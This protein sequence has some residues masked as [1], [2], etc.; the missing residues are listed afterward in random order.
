VEQHF[1]VI[2]RQFGHN[3]VRY[4]GL[5]KSTAPLKTEDAVREFEPLDGAVEA[6]DTRWT[7][8]FQDITLGTART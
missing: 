3:K 1:R 6:D 5:H 7:E 2:K 8:H 4:R